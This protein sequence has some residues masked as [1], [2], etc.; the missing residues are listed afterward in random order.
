[1]VRV[2]RGLHV[3]TRGSVLWRGKT[4]RDQR[5]CSN[6]RGIPL[7]SLPGKVNPW[8]PERRV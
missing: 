3:D 2:L 4:Q 7:I 8:V 6:Y 1:M 5:V